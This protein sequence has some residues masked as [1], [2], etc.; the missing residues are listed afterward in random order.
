MNPQL[1]KIRLL[2]RLAGAAGESQ[3]ADL[4][5]LL[6]QRLGDAPACPHLGLPTLPPWLPDAEQ[7]R[8]LQEAMAFSLRQGDPRLSEV[9]V[10]QRE[11]GEVHAFVVQARFIGGQAIGATVAIDGQGRLETSV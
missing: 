1:R 11:D 10:A 2:R 5:R 7:R 9:R 3:R 6:Q 8:H 4:H